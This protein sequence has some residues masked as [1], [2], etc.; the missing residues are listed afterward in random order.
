MVKGTSGCNQAVS[1]SNTSAITVRQA[2]RRS[3][4]AGSQ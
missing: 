2:R 4:E 3:D 1:R